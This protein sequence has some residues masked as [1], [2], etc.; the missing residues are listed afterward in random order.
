MNVL[1]EPPGRP[2]WIRL[3]NGSMVPRKFTATIDTPG[4]T[5][6][7]EVEVSDADGHSRLL[8]LV[9]VGE[10]GPV[11]ALPSIASLLKT[12]TGVAAGFMTFSRTF[13]GGGWEG[14]AATTEEAASAIAHQAKN[15]SPRIDARSNADLEKFASVYVEVE[16]EGNKSVV[17]E[18]GRRCGIA[19]SE[20]YRR[21]KRV[22]ELG[23]IDD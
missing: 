21:Y 6:K 12:A 19:R 9:P 13:E 7:V 22:R 1:V 20:A 14:K 17:E 2:D 16:A 11:S 10:P 15:P 4:G 8:S 5:V 18:A 3:R 23:L